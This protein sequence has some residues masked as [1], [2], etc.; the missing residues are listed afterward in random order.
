MSGYDDLFGVDGKVALVTGGSRGLGKMI[1]AGLVE[2]GARVYIVS[3]SE[4]SCARTAAE[5]AQRGTCEWIAGDLSTAAGIAAVAEE[6]GRREENL[7]LLVCN[8]GAAVVAPLDTFAEEQWD[9]VMDVNVKGVFLLVQALLGPLRAAAAVSGPSRVVTIGSVD[10]LSIQ[11]AENYSYA[12]SKAAVH[13]LTR[14]LSRRL[15]KESINVNCIAP[16]LFPTD[17]T[18]TY[19]GGGDPRGRLKTI[20]MQRPGEADDIVGAVV[21]LASRASN[22]VTGSV[23]PVSGGLGTIDSQGE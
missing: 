9:S 3:R 15:V 19:F 11:G 17:L 8:A 12:V 20:P 4:D 18:E 5:L 21:Y 16:G 1:A 14:V 7:D 23:L 2:R 13:Y 6:F 10:G 22:Y